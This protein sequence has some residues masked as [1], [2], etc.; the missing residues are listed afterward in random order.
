MN[1]L[2]LG[3]AL[4]TLLAAAPG[5][6]QQAEVSD[7]PVG[8]AV[9]RGRVIHADRPEAAADLPVVL[10]ALPRGGQPGLRR[11]TTDAEG[12]FRFEKISNDP[13][14]AYLVGTQVAGLPFG[15]RVVFAPGELERSLELRVGDPTSDASAVRVGEARVRI[16]WLGGRLRVTETYQLENT[17]ERVVF[18]AEGERAGRRPALRAALPD[19]ATRFASALLS[20]GAGLVRDG[21]EVLYWGP[22]HPGSQEVRFTYE[23]PA[24]QPRLELRKSFPSG[25]QP[26]RVLVHASVPQASSPQLEPG[27]PASLDTGEYRS[28]EVRALEPGASVALALELPEA[29]T[30][31]GTLA[32]PE[33]RIWLELDDVALQVDEEHRIRVTGD[34]PLVAASGEPLLRIDLP[35]GAKGLRLAKDALG[36]GVASAEGG[37]AVHG[38]LPPGDSTVAFRYR[39]PVQA[40]PARFER[41]FAHAS[42]L[43]SIFVADTGVAI[44]TDRL[45]RRRPIRTTDR[46]YLHLE[47]FEVGDGE[48]VALALSPLG[49]RARTGPAARL[50]SM[51]LLGV[52]AAWFLMAPLRRSGA[53]APAEVEEETDRSEREAIYASIRDLDDD[54]E[55]GKLEEADYQRLRDELRRR[56]VA[57]LQQERARTATRPAPAAEPAA[58]LPCPRCE[59]PS[60]PSDRFCAQCGQALGGAPS[61]STQTSASG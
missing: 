47:A 17:G 50:A 61:A 9:L 39:L 4:G 19:G 10:Y 14:T 2:A 58:A 23:V 43:L 3:V 27:D 37:L 13:T 18:A 52:A 33:V 32:V 42:P 5:R 60:R 45:H 56:A 20:S 38:P 46:F 29:A 51:A 49:R 53:R 31:L 28:L 34:L 44:E 36:L 55:T 15:G 48:R 57:L 1:R 30:D 16:D 54:F 7:V 41:T 12:R 22:V 40:V 59:S 24:A 25:A 35:P 11:A 26:L 21:S 8:P 6:A